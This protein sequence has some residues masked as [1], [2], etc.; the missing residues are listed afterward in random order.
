MNLKID[1]QLLNDLNDIADMEYS[2]PEGILIRGLI[3]YVKYAQRIDLTGSFKGKKGIEAAEKYI[4]ELSKIS[5]QDINEIVFG[6]IDAYRAKVIC[7]TPVKRIELSR[8]DEIYLFIDD[9]YRGSLLCLYSKEN[10]TN[11][12][13]EIMELQREKDKIERE[14][15]LNLFIENAREKLKLA[16]KELKQLESAYQKSNSEY[17]KIAN[18]HQILSMTEILKF[19]ARQR[20]EHKKNS[21]NKKREL[22]EI[23]RKTTN[24]SD[25]LNKKKYEVIEIKDDISTMN[26]YFNFDEIPI[27]KAK[28]KYSP[29][30]FNNLKNIVE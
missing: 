7:K 21:E 2:T 16:E 14:N 19:T 26:S 30:N 5:G 3:I 1:K 22:G 27:W 13:T 20:I 17:T 28:G 18:E 4:E 15:T 9:P 23:A 25:D 10:N 8:R 29:K 24:L 11:K 6:C 12:L